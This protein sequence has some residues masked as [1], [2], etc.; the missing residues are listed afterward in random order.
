MRIKKIVTGS[1]IV[2][3]A[4][5]AV[6]ASMSDLTP[7]PPSTEPEFM[8]S[9]DELIPEGT[10]VD[11]DVTI[12]VLFGETV[13]EMSMERYLI[14]V[15][16]AEMPASFELEALM[17]QATA[18]RTNAL[19]NMQVRPKSNHP[20]ADVCTEYTCCTAYGYDEQLQELW[21]SGYIEYAS[22]IINAVLK[23]DGKYVT[24][25]DEPILALFHSS[26]AGRTEACE[27]VWST[28]LPYL[29]SVYSPETEQDVTNYTASVTVQRPVF[30]N[31]IQNSYP[32]A[33]FVGNEES[34]I[35][36]ITLNESGRVD[37]MVIGGVPVKGT[38]LR[39]MFGL[40]STAI[41]Y[42]WV[43]RNI[44]FTTTGNGHGVGMSQY[45]A[46]VMAKGGRNYRDI[47]RSY[48]TDTIIMDY[49]Q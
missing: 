16:A 2:L 41:T 29:V 49:S 13:E 15:V 20:N 11:S 12:R 33:A 38:A 18:A 14:G 21:K 36:D 26:S 32:T 24:Y 30:I 39:T 23:T 46:N 40:R 35:K 31:T 34:W 43:D 22:K 17:A 9:L 28:G 44:V 7:E 42:E 5:V 10:R 47:L 45:G 48:Y 6:L 8:P 4:V 1:M 19:Y 3:M 27:N 25:E 37:E